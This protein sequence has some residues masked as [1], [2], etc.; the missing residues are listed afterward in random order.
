MSVASTA[1]LSAYCLD[2]AQ[3][4]S[5]AAAEL[6]CASG[7]DK[8]GWLRMGARRLREQAEAV[9]AANARDIE[10]APSFGLTAAAVDRLRLTADSV[11]SVAAALEEIAALPDPVGEVIESSIRPNGLEVQK[12]RVPLGVDLL[13]LRVAAERD[14]RRRRA[15]RQERQR[16]DPPRRQGSGP[17][18]P[19]HRR[20][21][22]RGAATKSACRPTP[23]NSSTR[24]TARPSATSCGCD[25]YIDLAIPRGGEGLI[26]RVAAEARMP[27]LKHFTGNCH[28]YVDAAADLDMAERIVGQRQ[29]PA[30]AACATPPSRC[31]STPP[32]PARSCRGSAGRCAARG[33]EIRGDER[34]AAA[35]AAAR[36]RPPTTT[37]RPSTS[38]P[39]IS[40]K[41]VDSLDEAIEHINRYGSQHTD[42]I[43][44][45]DL[46][47]ARAVHRR[48]DASA[49]MVN[50]STRFNDGCE[51]GLGAEIGIS[52]DKFHARG[53]C[54]LKELTTLQV[55][56]VRRRTGEV[57]RIR[58][59]NTECV[60][61][62]ST[63]RPT[64]SA[65][66]PREGHG[67]PTKFSVR[68]KSKACSMRWIAAPL[69]AAADKRRPRPPS[70]T[71]EDQPLRFQAARAR[72]Q[73]AD[74]GPAVAARRLR[75]QLRRGP[76]GAAA[77]HRRGQA[78]Q[79][80][81]AHLQRVR[82]QPGEPDL[83]QPAAG[84]AAGRQPDPRHQPVDPL[85]D[86][87]PAAGR[88]QRQRPPIAAAR[89][90]KSSCGWSAGSRA[91]FWTS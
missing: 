4:A 6:A 64:Q 32:S 15:L 36:R 22:R 80:R 87:R 81:S 52:T 12:V 11:A 8:D 61:R 77:Q 37:T 47:A 49:V 60:M 25:E 2:V 35:G 42:A 67:C 71:R 72:R 48:V 34:R 75:P 26:R 86:H 50:A 45:R 18:Q 29:V 55:R 57:V 13:H 53:P 24:P 27:V 43:V 79:R 70:P 9:L 21:P 90:P 83:L 65:S 5:R 19:G 3:R 41:V 76:L 59:R 68:P 69:R 56:G 39:I 89:S 28:V 14:R 40:V 33:V 10:A 91:S 20:D 84:R 88:R 16:R 82:L 46:A 7:A 17:L 44:T 1:S 73:G 23:C 51:F 78:D 74:A 31:W 38:D 85:P 54:G 66:A 30:A 58:M 63:T 62:C